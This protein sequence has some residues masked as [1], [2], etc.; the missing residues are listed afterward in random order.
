MTKCC[1]TMIKECPC[2]LKKTTDDKVLQHYDQTTTVRNK[3]STTLNTTHAAT[4]SLN[5]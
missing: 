4:P 5:I 2:M 3:L 1:N